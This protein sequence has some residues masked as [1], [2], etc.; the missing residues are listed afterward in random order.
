MLKQQLILLGILAIAFLIL[1]VRLLSKTDS[2]NTVAALFLVVTMI[3]SY[4]FFAT[5]TINNLCEKSEGI[6]PEYEKLENVYQRK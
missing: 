2:R 5:L 6:C 1:F 3:L 4:A